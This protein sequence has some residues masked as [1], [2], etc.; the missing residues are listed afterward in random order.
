[1]NSL[2]VTP[3]SIMIVLNQSDQNGEWLIAATTPEILES[4]RESFTPRRG[5][6]V[7]RISVPQSE[8]GR[9]DPPTVS[10]VGGMITQLSGSYV[11]LAPYSLVEMRNPPEFSYEPWKGHL[12]KSASEARITLKA[13]RLPRERGVEFESTL[14]S[15]SILNDAELSLEGLLSRHQ[16]ANSAEDSSLKDPFEYVEGVDK[17]LPSSVKRRLNR[18]GFS[19]KHPPASPE[20]QRLKILASNSPDSLGCLTFDR[21]TTLAS[22]TSGYSSS[23]VRRVGNEGLG[24]SSVDSSSSRLFHFNSVSCDSS[25]PLSPSRIAF[26]PVP[27]DNSDVN[28]LEKED[29]GVN[30]DRSFAFGLSIPSL[31]FVSGSS[32]DRNPS[33]ISEI[34][35]I[36]LHTDAVAGSSDIARMNEAEISRAENRVDSQLTLDESQ[37]EFDD[38]LAE[39]CAGGDREQRISPGAERDISFFSCQEDGESRKQKTGEQVTRLPLCSYR[40]VKF[41]TKRYVINNNSEK[42]SGAYCSANW[43]L[44][45]DKNRKRQLLPL[46]L[47]MTSGLL[48]FRLWCS[49]TLPH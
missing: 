33:T 14:S 2:G 3:L 4:F 41:V 26:C 48:S 10:S 40:Y 21:I 8:P 5:V 45:A 29:S 42:F 22:S 1:M 46:I 43:R 27:G 38:D 25:S 15:Y 6:R 31:K 19:F 17:S 34:S 12:K 16:V 35:E 11:D 32:R 24:Q 23:P 47:K 9:S 39:N 7:V 18:D 28:Y 13:L 20:T 49:R 36:S 37:L 30:A 44:N